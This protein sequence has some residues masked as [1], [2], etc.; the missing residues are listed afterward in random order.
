MAAC[1]LSKHALRPGL[2]LALMGFGAVR[3]HIRGAAAI[4]AART[5]I[6]TVVQME[7]VTPALKARPQGKN[8]VLL[9]GRLM[10]KKMIERW[11][12]FCIVLVIR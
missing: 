9:C 10:G 4:F 2:A 5:D 8:R 12:I 6:R 1:K 7:D 3:M 11:L